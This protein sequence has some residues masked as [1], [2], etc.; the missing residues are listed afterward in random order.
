MKTSPNIDLKS[1]H[2]LLQFSQKQEETIHVLEE[3]LALLTAK[4]FGKKSEKFQELNP[5]Q[6][7][8]LAQHALEN[9]VELEDLL[10]REVKA[11]KRK[12]GR[13]PFPKELSRREVIHDISQEDKICSCGCELQKIGEEKS[14]QL[15]FI[16]AKL[17]VIVNIRPK[18]TCKH[19]E[20]DSQVF[21]IA[22]V[23]AQII[24]KSIATASLLAHLMISKF[25]D[26][27]PFYRQ[28]KQLQRLGIEISRN[29]MIRWAIQLGILLKRLCELLHHEILAGDLIHIDE[30]SIQVLKEEGKSP[31]SKSYM[32]ILRG[33]AGVYFKYSRNRS[34]DMAK[35][36][37]HRFEGAVVS[38]A[39]VGYQFL[40]R[41]VKVLHA[42]CW[43]HARRKFDEVIKSKGKKGKD[44]N[45]EKALLLIKKLYKVEYESEDLKEK[46]T[47]RQ[48]KSKLILAELHTFLLNK[49]PQVLPSSLLGKAV[50]YTLNN[51]DCLNVFTKK[52]EIPLDNNAA[53]NAIRPFVIG[54]KNWL[55]C[56][57]VAGAEA[58][59]RLYSLIETAKA[60]QL[61]PNE[62]LKTLFE[63]LP[64]ANSEEK[65]KALLPQYIQLEQS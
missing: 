58:S 37:L 49:Q 65:L 10:E 24:P 63:Q 41:E 21:K 45:A 31:S 40:D 46:L 50:N 16:P 43:A 4:L 23:P 22:P 51:W 36:L 20:Q 29:N 26:A 18:Y 38:D 14:E 9:P 11:H 48:T 44:G 3:K 60:K 30:T 54:R 27:L 59:A 17:E 64:Q 19:C 42:G 39:Y 7:N 1:Y 13:K 57:T 32:W 53:E 6:L 56:D 35:E 5:D 52:A 55:F 62:Y 8:F 28:E 2:R 61:N 12:G 47:L 25:I 15:E 33:D 34:S